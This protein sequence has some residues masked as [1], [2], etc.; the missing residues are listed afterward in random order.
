[1][2]SSGLLLIA[3]GTVAYAIGAG[4][5]IVDA[6]YFSVSTLT[7][8]SVADPSLTL[9][10]GWLKL[11]T[12]MYQLLGIGILVEILRRLATSFVAVRVEEDAGD[13]PV[14]TPEPS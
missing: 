3:L 9:E 10:S 14:A 8:T 2:L 7:T 12:V 5:S 11:F 13:P 1:M 4:W 6:V